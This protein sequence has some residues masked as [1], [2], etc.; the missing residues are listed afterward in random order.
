MFTALSSL[1]DRPKQSTAPTVALGNPGLTSSHK[2]CDNKLTELTQVGLLRIYFS[3]LLTFQTSF[4]SISLHLPLRSSHSHF[5]TT[6]G[7]SIQWKSMFVAEDIKGN[8]VR[9][10]IANWS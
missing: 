4:N 8:Q 3:N 1:N 2:L 5:L 7:C 10:A 9:Q 6:V